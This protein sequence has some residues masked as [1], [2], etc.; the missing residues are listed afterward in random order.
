MRKPNDT[1]ASAPSTMMILQP[2]ERRILKINKTKGGYQ[3]LE[4]WVK[5]NTSSTSGCCA[6]DPVHFERLVRCIQ[7][8]G[9]GG[10]NKRLR[11]A[12]IPALRRIGIDLAP[13]WGAI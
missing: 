1:P 3:D 6:L 12:C 13:G 9:P 5:R 4:N 10:P 11:D 2:H 8:Y 7:N